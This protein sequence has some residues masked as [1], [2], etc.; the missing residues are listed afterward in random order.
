MYSPINIYFASRNWNLVPKLFSSL[1][2]TPFPTSLFLKK[3]QQN[4]HFNK[5]IPE[6]LLTYRPCSK[7]QTPQY[8]WA[9]LS[10]L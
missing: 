1:S 2:V 10:H 3:E 9:K 4:V 6:M 8:Y 7:N 5:C